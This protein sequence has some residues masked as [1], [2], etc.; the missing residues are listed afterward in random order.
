MSENQTPNFGEMLRAAQRVQEEI[1]RVQQELAHKSVEGAAGGGLVVVRANG[2]NQLLAVEIDKQL[3]DP[4]ERE[5]LQDL[6]VAAVNQA[7]AKSTELAQS[8]LAK[9][10]GGLPIKLPGGLI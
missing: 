3:L 4:E 6:V 5:M 9:I 2:R 1:Q 10:T 8:E 7:L